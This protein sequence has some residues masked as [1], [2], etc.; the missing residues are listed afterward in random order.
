MIKEQSIHKQVPLI[1]VR[2]HPGIESVRVNLPFQRG[3]DVPLFGYDLRPTERVA[4][5]E[6]EAIHT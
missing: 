2:V 1:K 5:K 6:S 4:R 3:H